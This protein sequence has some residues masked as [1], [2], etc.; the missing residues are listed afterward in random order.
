MT[1][2]GFYIKHRNVPVFVAEIDQPNDLP[3]LI[4]AT[5]ERGYV[6]DREERMVYPWH[7]IHEI[8]YREID[9]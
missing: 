2:V 5:I 7:R 4:Q 3:E 1:K 8:C 9:A 6:L